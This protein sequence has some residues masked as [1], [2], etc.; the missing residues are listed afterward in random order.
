MAVVLVREDEYQILC[1]FKA[2]SG[3]GKTEAGI[4]Y[5]ALL[6]WGGGQPDNS[7]DGP[8]ASHQRTCGLSSFQGDLW[9]YLCS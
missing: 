2:E 3:T 7:L 8:Q 6:D 4:V 9:G 1:I 5:A